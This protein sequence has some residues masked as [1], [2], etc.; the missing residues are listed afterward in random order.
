MDWSW[1]A[2]AKG[3]AD[4]AETTRL[5]AVKSASHPSSLARHRSTDRPSRVRLT[6]G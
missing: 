5:L 2:F 4:A 3:A 1:D 6:D